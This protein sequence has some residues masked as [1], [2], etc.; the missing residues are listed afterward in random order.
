MVE[1]SRPFAAFENSAHE[2]TLSPSCSTA[3]AS[4]DSSTTDTPPQAPSPH[5]SATINAPT[6]YA[7]NFFIPSFSTSSLASTPRP[8]PRSRL[9]RA[10]G[11][12]TSRLSVVFYDDEGYGRAAYVD[13]AGGG[14]GPRGPVGGVGGGY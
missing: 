1:V 5:P 11:E 9:R 8:I 7:S 2:L 3:P 14:F 10:N 12:A 6:S 13:G 4:D